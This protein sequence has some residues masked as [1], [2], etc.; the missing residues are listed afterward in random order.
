MSR[1]TPFYVPKPHFEITYAPN[2]IY[3]YYVYEWLDLGIPF[4]IG[5]G[6]TYRAWALHSQETEERR[7]LATKFRIRIIKHFLTKPLAHKQERLLIKQRI[8]QG[9]SLTNQRIP[10]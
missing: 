5:M 9:Y 4:Y 10:C 8:R 3:G 1:F 6:Q 2:P 7:E